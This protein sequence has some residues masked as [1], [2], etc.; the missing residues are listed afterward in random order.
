MEKKIKRF[1]RLATLRKRDISKEITN[2]NLLINKSDKNI[3]LTENNDSYLRNLAKDLNA[4]IVNHNNFIGGRY[5][6]LSEVGMLPAQLM[7]LNEKKFKRFNS[8]IKNKKFINT[9][10][11]NVS[12][13]LY[14]KNK[15]KLNS[16]ILNYDEKSEVKRVAI[17]I[18][19]SLGS[20]FHKSTL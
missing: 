17:I 13:I 2:S 14:L 11:Q 3:F 16:I 7:G 20:C 18:L 1:Q 5:S 19:L 6:V 9:L 12:N 15:G 4:E 10:V 8:L